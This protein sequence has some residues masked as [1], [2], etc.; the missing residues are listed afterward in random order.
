MAT[1]LGAPNFAVNPIRFGVTLTASTSVDRAGTGTT[2]L[3]TA[4]ASAA[5]YVG[6]VR[7]DRILANLNGTPATSIACVIR[8]FTALAGGSTKILRAEVSV[9]ALTGTI[10]TANAAQTVVATTAGDLTPA[11]TLGPG[12][13]LY[14]GVYAASGTDVW[15]IEGIGGSF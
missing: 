2:L 7:I 14:G 4:P 15:G 10:G 13:T 1:T 8:I 9:A 6:G 3:Y 12:E 5:N 11:I